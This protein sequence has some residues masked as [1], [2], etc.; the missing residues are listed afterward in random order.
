MCLLKRWVNSP[1]IELIV[2]YVLEKCPEDLANAWA[3][4]PVENPLIQSEPRRRSLFSGPGL[5]TMQSQV[6]NLAAIPI[7]DHISYLSKVGQAQRRIS[8]ALLEKA[9]QD[10]LERQKKKDG[11]PKKGHSKSAIENASHRADEEQKLRKVVQH[12]LDHYDLS[13]PDSPRKRPKLPIQTLTTSELPASTINI[14][15]ILKVRDV[16]EDINETSPLKSI[17]I[18]RTAS[19]KLNYLLSRILELKEEE[20]II[21]FSDYGPM[22]W[23]LGEALELLGIEHLI[24]IQRL[25][26]PHRFCLTADASA[27]VSICC[28]V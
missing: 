12:E 5:L 9:R 1:R 28:N 6:L 11:T 21:V 19:A 27:T 26:R 4:L 22:M 20:K 7:E 8:Q 25:V 18:N 2:G 15:S 10:A 16:P 23:Y 13:K 14:K 17:K 24:Y 3:L